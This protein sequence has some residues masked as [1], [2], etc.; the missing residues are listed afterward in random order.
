MSE[1]N[2]AHPP[3]QANTPNPHISLLQYIILVGVGAF[4]TTFAQ[5][6]II[7]QLPTTFLLKDHLKL[8]REE[9]SFFFFVATFAWNL[10][11]FAGIFTDAFPIFGTRR[12]SYM[13]LGAVGAAVGWAVMAFIP[14]LFGPLLFASIAMN[15]ATVFSST[16]MGGLMVEAGQTFGASGRISSLRQ[17]VQS[18]S[19]V[20]G[21]LLGGALASRMIT[22]PTKQF[23][24]KWWMIT[25]AI[26]A[27]SMVL[28]GVITVLV[29]KEPRIRRTAALADAPA[30]IRIPLAM[31]I[32]L[33]VVAL[34][35]TAFFLNAETRN[36]GWSLYS[37][38]GMFILFIG[39]AKLPTRRAVVVNAQNQLGDVF[40]SKTLWMAVAMLLLVYTVPGFNTTLTYRQ[41]DVMHFQKE[42]I[43]WLSSLEGIAGILAAALYAAVCKKVNLR[44]L[45]LVGVGS[46]A[47]F[48]L[49]YLLY[50]PGAGLGIIQVV[51]AVVGFCVVLAEL[52]LMDLAVRSTPKG[53]EAMGFA[54]M[55]SVRN[56]GIALSDLLGSKMVDM[57]LV[58]FNSMV[59]IN[60]VTTLVILFF[61]PFL[62][63]AVLRRKEGENH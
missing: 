42:F 9:V 36:I 6:R 15:I 44:N 2:A 47:V 50:Q 27:V 1:T 24:A 29:L 31:P 13:V 60:A 35:A 43:G 5:Q 4:A 11:P 18:L 58:E 39:L 10:K 22:G 3:Q 28:L 30:D 56:F 17:V 32:V 53:C 33:L 45:I 54:L 20:I 34:A 63:K 46:N 16:V 61:V 25:M 21:P 14:N 7:G 59:I 12:K 52:S 8:S 19:V 62:P 37:L 23:D 40:A 49:L 55:M 41:D 48:T 26:A 57:K 51:H 38:V